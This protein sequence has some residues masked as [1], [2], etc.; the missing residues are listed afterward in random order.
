M[1]GVHD[2][3]VAVGLPRN[4]GGVEIVDEA[5]NTLLALGGEA[6]VGQVVTVEALVAVIGGSMAERKVAHSNFAGDEPCGNVDRVVAG[7]LDVRQK[8]IP[9]LLQFVAAHGQHQ[10]NGVVDTLRRIWCRGGSS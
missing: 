3:A 9:V 2:G 8:R 7:G 6:A 5:V 1:K 4:G 10:G